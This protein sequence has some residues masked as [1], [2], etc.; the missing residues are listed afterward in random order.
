M[1]ENVEGVNVNGWKDTRA[2]DGG[3]C[4]HGCGAGMDGHVGGP[5]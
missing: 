4:T 5:H 3:A 1:R 2:M